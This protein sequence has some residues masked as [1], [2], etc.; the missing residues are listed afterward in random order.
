MHGVWG[1]KRIGTSAKCEQNLASGGYPYYLFM[2][3]RSLS[4]KVRRAD[5]AGC[6]AWGGFA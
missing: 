3:P 2:W 1:V 6:L 5:V 4:V